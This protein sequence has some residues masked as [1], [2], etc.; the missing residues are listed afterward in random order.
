M[1]IAKKIGPWVAIAGLLTV[2]LTASGQAAADGLS[3]TMTPSNA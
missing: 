2:V 1:V 3:T